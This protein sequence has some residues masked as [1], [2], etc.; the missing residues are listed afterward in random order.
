MTHSGE[1]FYLL[2]CSKALGKV[3]VSKVAEPAPELLVQCISKLAPIKSRLKII[4]ILMITPRLVFLVFRGCM[5]VAKA[6]W[7]VIASQ[8]LPWHAHRVLSRLYKDS[9]QPGEVV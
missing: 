2:L 4:S 5:A 1:K 8:L 7:R 6:S 3:G 9:S